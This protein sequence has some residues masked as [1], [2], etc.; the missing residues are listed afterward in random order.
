MVRKLRGIV[1]DFMGQHERIPSDFEISELA[2]I[3]EDEVTRYLGMG[4]ETTSLFDEYSDGLRYIDQLP[5][6]KIY[7]VMQIKFAASRL[8]G[9]GSI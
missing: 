6:V 5:D 8:A 2:G 7:L 1:E 9:M 4:C 3:R